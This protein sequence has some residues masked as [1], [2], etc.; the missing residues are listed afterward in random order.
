MANVDD[1]LREDIFKLLHLEGLGEEQKAALIEKMDNTIQ[2][3]L[4]TRIASILSEQ[5]AERFSQLAESNDQEG[6]KTLLTTNGID[7]TQLATE[8]AIRFRVE[9]VEMIDL[10]TQNN[11]NTDQ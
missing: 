6:M 2:A 10:A 11:S 9:L 5:E 1:L 3:R 7:A 4:V 8:E